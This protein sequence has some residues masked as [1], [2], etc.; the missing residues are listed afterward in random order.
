[1]LNPIQSQL[2]LCGLRLKCF[3]SK[4]VL[5]L[6]TFW[7]TITNPWSLQSIGYTHIWL[8]SPLHPW[9]NNSRADTLYGCLDTTQLLFIVIKRNYTFR[10]MEICFLLPPQETLSLQKLRWHTLFAMLR[11]NTEETNVC[12][13]LMKVHGERREWGL[14]WWCTFKVSSPYILGCAKWGSVPVQKKDKLCN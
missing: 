9:H 6:I 14:L 12:R 7:W 13:G 3:V 10:T 8:L 1:M 11:R 4:R 2:C 5:D